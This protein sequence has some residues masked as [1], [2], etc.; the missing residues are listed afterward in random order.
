MGS[1]AH[2]KE[3]CVPGLVT[4][5]ITARMPLVGDPPKDMSGDARQSPRS[6]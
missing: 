2:V 5:E 3:A 6:R 1:E 4:G